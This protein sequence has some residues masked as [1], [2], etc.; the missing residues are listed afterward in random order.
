MQT[1]KMNLIT[2]GIVPTANKQ[3]TYCATYIEQTTM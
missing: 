3:F 1:D 2:M